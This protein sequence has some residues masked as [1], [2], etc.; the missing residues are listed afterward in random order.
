MNISSDHRISWLSEALGLAK[1]CEPTSTAYNVGCVITT[2]GSDPRRV[3]DGYSRELPGNTHAEECAINKLTMFSEPLVLYSTMEPCSTRL[4]GKESCTKRILAC[5]MI[6]TVVI[7]VR[8]PDKFVKCEGVDELREHGV[9]V[10]FG[11]DEQLAE[12]ALKLATIG[13]HEREQ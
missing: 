11:D 6:R 5:P 12:E 3:A 9:V 8:E 2:D 7:G 1:K 10:L 13:H 4:S